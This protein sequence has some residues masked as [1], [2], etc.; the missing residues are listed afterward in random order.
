MRKTTRCLLIN[1][2]ETKYV[3]AIQVRNGGDEETRVKNSEASKLTAFRTSHSLWTKRNF[4]IFA[5]FRLRFSLRRRQ[6]GRRRD[7][8]KADK[9][10]EGC[11]QKL[12]VVL[13]VREIERIRRNAQKVWS[14][15]V[16]LHSNGVC[17]CNNTMLCHPLQHE[18]PQK[19]FKKLF[20]F[21]NTKESG[22]AQSSWAIPLIDSNGSFESNKIFAKRRCR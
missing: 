5:A 11:K 20:R 14:W 4:L 13:L 10:G 9:R 21:A 2:R 17:W 1:G 3:S 15:T 22:R 12:L 19:N 8:L 7:W 18:K 6:K 16:E